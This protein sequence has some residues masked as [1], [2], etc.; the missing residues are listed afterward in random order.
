ME[1]A[2][3]EDS[4]EDSA[5]IEGPGILQAAVLQQGNQTLA[6]S[7]SENDVQSMGRGAPVFGVLRPRRRVSVTCTLHTRCD[8]GRPAKEYLYTTRDEAT[9]LC[10]PTTPGLTQART[11]QQAGSSA[12]P[13]A[14][15]VLRPRKL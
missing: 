10:Q 5:F 1:S 2:R 8:G 3:I 15:G 13:D 11:S 14:R 12:G 9:G 7:M 6:R 4:S